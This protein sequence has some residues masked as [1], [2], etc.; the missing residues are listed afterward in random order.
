MAV[1]AK[2]RSSLHKV[3]CDFNKAFLNKI[4][5]LVVFS[6][7][8][9]PLTAKLHRKSLLL[10]KLFPNFK[11]EKHRIILV[12]YFKQRIEINEKIPDIA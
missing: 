12:C 2:S 10:N 5:Y 9:F 6:C 8:N 1:V 7:K 3:K 4:L 11:L